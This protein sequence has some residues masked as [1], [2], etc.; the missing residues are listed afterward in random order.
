[1]TE[2]ERLQK[3]VEAETPEDAV[4]FLLHNPPEAPD[5]NEA[6]AKGILRD[7]NNWLNGVRDDRDRS[8]LPPKD[9]GI[10]AIAN[11]QENYRETGRALPVAW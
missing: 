6:A 7:I 5:G 8:N 11:L 2:L 10:R 4:R 1:M 3:V 9:R